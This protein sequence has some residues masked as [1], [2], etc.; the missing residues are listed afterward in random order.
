MRKKIALGFGAALPEPR[1]V[2]LVEGVVRSVSRPGLMIDSSLMTEMM[3]RVGK[4][5]TR[6]V[7]VMKGCGMKVCFGEDRERVWYRS[8]YWKAF[9][10]EGRK[11]TRGIR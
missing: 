2:L 11:R 5:G 6:G 4:K 8:P 3:Y 7:A 1:H 10:I 9:I